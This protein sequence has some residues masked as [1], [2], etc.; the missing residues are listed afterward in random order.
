MVARRRNFWR[1][2][3]AV[4]VCDAEILMGSAFPSLG[5]PPPLH[6]DVDVGPPGVVTLSRGARDWESYHERLPQRAERP[7][8][9]AH[10]RRARPQT[11][12][13]GLPPVRPRQPLRSRRSTL[14]RPDWC[15]RLSGP[16]A[17]TELNDPLPRRRLSSVVSP[18]LI[19]STAHRREKGT[20]KPV[21][22]LRQRVSCCPCVCGGESSPGD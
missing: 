2:R 8:V 21:C 6:G 14:C 13:I 19:A 16:Q 17:R 10:L 20:M 22:S 1:R 7:H 12:V 18:V 9:V 11:R 3:T 4:R 15:G 5:S